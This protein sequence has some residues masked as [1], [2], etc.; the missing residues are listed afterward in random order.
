MLKKGKKKQKSKA[1]GLLSACILPAFHINYSSSLPGL[2]L[3]STLP[4]QPGCAVVDKVPQ[5]QMASSHWPAPAAFLSI[6]V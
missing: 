1:E 3:P 2:L 4:Y 5:A 6:L